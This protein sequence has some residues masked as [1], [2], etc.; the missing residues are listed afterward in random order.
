MVDIIG[1][2]SR[3]PA[4]ADLPDDQIEWFLSQSEEV[5]LKPGDIIRAAGR[6]RR[7][8]CSSFWKASLHGAA[9]SAAKPSY[10]RQGGRRDRGPA[11]L[12]NEAIHR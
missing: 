6:S 12:T 9:N 5:H 2:S 11:V 1:A 8:P 7:M 4:F 10:S 3:V